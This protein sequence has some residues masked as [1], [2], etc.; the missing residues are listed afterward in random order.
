MG[1]RHTLGDS[2]VS[3]EFEEPTPST[4]RLRSRTIAESNEN[5]SQPRQATQ[6]RRKK[7]APTK[8]GVRALREIRLLQMRTDFMIPR[9]PFSRLVREIICQHSTTVSKVT[10]A[11][12]EALQTATEAYIEQKLH[13]AYMLTLHRKCVTLHINDM[14]LL[15]ILR[16]D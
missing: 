11:A 4:L 5:Q 2:D 16:I 3:S 9:L 6:S 10:S 12:F 14:R 8:R 15:H 1:S 13:D 7:T